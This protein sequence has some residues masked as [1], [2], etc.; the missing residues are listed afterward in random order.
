MLPMRDRAFEVAVISPSFIYIERCFGRP[1]RAQ[2]K[3]KVHR[4]VRRETPDPL[5]QRF[6]IK[7]GGRV[8]GMLCRHPSHQEILQA[9]PGGP[10]EIP[11]AVFPPKD[12][13]IR[14]D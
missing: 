6:V 13:A 3:I 5:M 10:V 8:H 12:A 7:I 4:Q 11:K 14:R 2:N 1:N 9:E